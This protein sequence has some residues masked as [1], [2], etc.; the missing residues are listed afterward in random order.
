MRVERTF[1]GISLRL[2]RRYLESLGGTVV[3]QTTV[4]APAWRATLATE[5]V[6]IGPTLELTEVTVRFEGE[7]SELTPVVEAFARK[8]MRAGG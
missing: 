6:R 7:E 2:A 4:E 3:D 5:S 1:R 8:A